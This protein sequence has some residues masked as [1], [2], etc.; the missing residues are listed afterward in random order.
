VVREKLELNQVRM[1]G[2]EGS[3]EKMLY[4]VLQ[5][6]QYKYDEVKIR[7]ELARMR[8]QI[9]KKVTQSIYYILP[10]IGRHLISGIFTDV[11]ALERIKMLTIEP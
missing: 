8:T 9:V 1:S 7:N 2:Y 5:K 10:K 6:R 11:P 3:T 4:Q